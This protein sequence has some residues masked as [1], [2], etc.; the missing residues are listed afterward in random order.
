MGSPSNE[1][2][3]KIEI[4]KHIIQF[5]IDEFD[6][7]ILPTPNYPTSNQDIEQQVNTIWEKNLH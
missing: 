6:F 2:R 4:K 3:D 1:I 5:R 7:D